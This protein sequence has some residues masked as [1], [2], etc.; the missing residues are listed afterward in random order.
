VPLDSPSP[1]ETHGS[2]PLSGLIAAVAT[3]FTAGGALDL[4]AFDRILTLLLEAG[5]D[6]VCLG[7]ATAEYAHTTLEERVT[8]I[9]RTA[10]QLDRR[11]ALV[12]GIGAASPRDV[13]PLGEVAFAA[14]ARAVLVPAPLFFPYGQ[15][16]IMAFCRHVATQLG[17]PT[18]LYDLPH[19]TTPLETDTILELLR[20]ETSIVGIKDSSGRRERL[21]LLAEARG[22]AP[23]HLI[24]GDDN[25]LTDAMAAGWDGCISGPAGMCPELLVALTA[26]ARRGDQATTDALFTLLRDLIAQISRFPTP[27][28]IR[29]GLS[30]RG[31]DTGPMPLPLSPRR[32][33]DAAALATWLPGWFDRVGDALGAP[34]GVGSGL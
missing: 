17:G 2:P 31:I 7:G 22:D 13:I 30:G 33:A 4:V 6:G 5:V 21:P 12:V 11:T 10:R 18:L 26:A 1:A 25:A 29:L 3:P 19:F 28:G 14:G 27:W 20:D 34:V 32:A 24:V 16:D 23:W 15:E 9:E 8:L